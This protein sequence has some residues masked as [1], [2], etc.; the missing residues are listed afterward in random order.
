MI[1]DS[2]ASAGERHGRFT[3]PPLGA[4]AAVIVWSPLPRSGG[5]GTG[6]SGSASTEDRSKHDR[7]CV[8]IPR[9]PP[10]RAIAP[11]P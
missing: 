3:A 2:D 1:L 9:L 5:E 6:V 4:V 8:S 7:V 10:R 11:S